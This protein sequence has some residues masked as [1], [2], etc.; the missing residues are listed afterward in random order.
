MAQNIPQG[1]PRD[2]HSNFYIEKRPPASGHSLHLARQTRD[3]AKS[4][5]FK[6]G[7][8]NPTSEE[9]KQMEHADVC[10]NVN[11]IYI[12]TGPKNIFLHGTIITENEDKKSKERLCNHDN[13]I[14]CFSTNLTR[15]FNSKQPQDSIQK[16]IVCATNYSQD[17]FHG[18]T[19]DVEFTTCPYFDE[20]VVDFA[21][22]V[23][24]NADP[25]E[26]Q[27]PCSYSK[28]VMCYI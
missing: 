8:D 23:I 27:T 17:S 22:D 3:R 4:Q 5:A 20:D 13:G 2:E 25:Q 15:I 16:T 21:Y 24:P 19:Y 9:I 11:S 18:S 10:M 28:I 7:F 26:Q 1:T 14:Q 12:P 6:L